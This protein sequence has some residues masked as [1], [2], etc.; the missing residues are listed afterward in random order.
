MTLDSSVAL[1]IRESII[2]F[3]NLTFKNLIFMQV[4]LDHAATTPV[5]KRVLEVML[6]YFQTEFGNP[7]SIH[8]FGQKALWAV[9]Q[10]RQTI[11]EALGC[12]AGE[13]YFTS[14]A[15][16][17]NNLAIKGYA[18]AHQ[19]EGKHLIT[20]ALEHHCVLNS[21]EDLQQEGF[22]VDLIQP[23][24]SGVINPHE[25]EK[26]IRPDTLL[27]SVM[28]ANNEIGTLQPIAEIGQFCRQK[29]I[30]FHSDAVQAFG[31]EKCE[32]NQ[33]QV[34]ALTLSAHKFYGPKGVGCLYLRKETVLRPILS[35]GGQENGLRSGTHNVPGIVGMGKAVEL[36]EQEREK[37]TRAVREKRDL[38]W[39]LLRKIPDVRVNGD[40]E[41]RLP[42]NLNLIFTEVNGEA[43]LVR[44]DLEGIAVSTGSAC[45]ASS[46]KLSHV[47]LALGLDE[48]SCKSS[49]R[50]TLGK[51]NTEEEVR[52]AAE[53]IK[54]IVEELRSLR[55]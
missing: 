2:F 23:D 55:L 19:K 7:S 35:G 30:F 16:E 39:D 33:L 46:T 29:K 9:D 44:L 49:L 5:N 14:G 18:R 28:F 24:S 31:Y 3:V 8:Q 54:L 48:K 38:L 34:D 4:Y 25:I 45:S 43:L 13:I 15:T 11:A 51:D 26:R 6:P 21:C 10:A 37:N 22:E 53:K 1:G 47:L 32:V 17:A 36:I 20:T 52:Y 40:L 50:V 12:S 41:K 27:V 42:N